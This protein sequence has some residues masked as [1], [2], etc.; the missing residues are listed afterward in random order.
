MD[1]QKDGK[2]YRVQDG[3]NEF[4]GIELTVNGKIAD[5]WNAMGGITYLNGK[6]NRSASVASGTKINGTPKW[7]GV[8]S[9]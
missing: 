8:M 9:L 2:W 5:K 6:V 4:K 1:V 7:N 3:E